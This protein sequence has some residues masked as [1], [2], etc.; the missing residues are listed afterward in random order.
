MSE[1]TS[2]RAEPPV[3]KRRKRKDPLDRLLTKFEIDFE[4]GCWNWTACITPAGYG[5][6]WYEYRRNNFAHRAAWI[7]LVGPIPEGMVIDHL[8][9]NRRCCNP[10][11]LEVVTMAENLLRGDGFAGQ[12]VRQPNYATHCP[13]GH[14]YTPENTY[15]RPKGKRRRECRTC[16]NTY[17][18]RRQQRELAAKFEQSR[19]A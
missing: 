12:R 19:A 9:K 4:T 15:V 5:Q 7:E 10:D 17:K 14:E 16:R 3:E 6:F 1:S 13:N 2:H 8:C 11:H 18:A